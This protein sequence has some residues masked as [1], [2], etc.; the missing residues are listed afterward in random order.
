MEKN[1]TDC[2]KPLAMIRIAGKRPPLQKKVVTLSHSSVMQ[3]LRF[4]CDVRWMFVENNKF[5]LW[6]YVF[7][8][9]LFP[10]CVLF[11]V[12]VHMAWGLIIHNSHLLRNDLMENINGWF[13]VLSSRLSLYCEQTRKVESNE[14]DRIFR[15]M[16]A[17]VLGEKIFLLM[18][19]LVT[20]TRGWISLFLSLAQKKS[21]MVQYTSHISTFF[22]AWWPSRAWRSVLGL[23]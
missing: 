10:F 14:S 11:S 8:T 23:L 17:K 19:P 2:N 15:I 12:C 5:M 16:N 9:S 21:V 1:I 20:R 4:S 7:S 22:L 6:K 13:S 3:I 18:L